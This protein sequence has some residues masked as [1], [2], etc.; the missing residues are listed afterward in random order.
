MEKYLSYFLPAKVPLKDLNS[1]FTKDFLHSAFSIIKKCEFMERHEV[2]ITN[3]FSPENFLEELIN[4][5]LNDGTL[6]YPIDANDILSNAVHELTALMQKETGYYQN[7]FNYIDKSFAPLIRISKPRSTDPPPAVENKEMPPE[8]T[9]CGIAFNSF[10]KSFSD[11]SIFPFEMIKAFISEINDNLAKIKSDELVGTES[12]IKSMELF[13]GNIL[14]VDE[15]ATSEIFSLLHPLIFNL[16]KSLNTVNFLLYFFK[17]VLKHGEKLKI[18][19]MNLTDYL[20]EIDES[21][22]FNKIFKFQEKIIKISFID[23][24]TIGVLTNQKNV[25]F[26]NLTTHSITKKI[27]FEDII[28]TNEIIN[29]DDY[30]ICI[31]SNNA[32]I[33]SNHLISCFSLIDGSRFGIVSSHAVVDKV[34]FI[35]FFNG[36][37]F[38]FGKKETKYIFFKMPN[39]PHSFEISLCT[40]VSID[41]DPI[42][43]IVNSNI[44]FILNFKNKLIDFIYN[45]DGSINR[46]YPS[47]TH[48]NKN[49]PSADFL[50]RIYAYAREIKEPQNET[51]TQ[52]EFSYEVAVIYT[53]LTLYKDYFLISWKKNDI[54]GEDSETEHKNKAYIEKMIIHLKLL[55]NQIF[56]KANFSRDNINSSFFTKS[57]SSTLLQLLELC[58]MAISNNYSHNFTIFCLFSL[59][60]NIHQG[61]KNLTID[62]I[63]KIIQFY[64]KM[65]HS[66][67]SIKYSY[68]QNYILLS[69]AI[70]HHTLYYDDLSKVKDDFQ[71]VFNDETRLQNLLNYDLIQYLSKSSAFVYIFNDDLIDIIIKH[72]PPIC[73]YHCLINSEKPY[74]K[75]ACYNPP[76]KILE[77]YMK[78][79]IKYI[80]A[81]IDDN[82]IPTNIY[83]D[84]LIHYANC[85][86]SMNNHIPFIFA[87]MVSKELSRIHHCLSKNESFAESDIKY[88]TDSFDHDYIEKERVAKFET[89]HGS[90]EIS[91][92]KAVYI[93]PGAA[94]IILEF[95]K[96]CQIPKK[97]EFTISYTEF[98]GKQ[99]CKKITKNNKDKIPSMTIKSDSV[100]L[101]FKVPHSYYIWR[102]L[103]NIKGTIKKDKFEFSPDISQFQFCYLVHLVGKCLN[104][105]INSIPITSREEEC[106]VL[107]SYNI[108]QHVKIE[109]Y[110]ELASKHPI[111]S[112][113]AKKDLY[114][115]KD[116]KMHITK[117]RRTISRGL[118]FNNTTHSSDML[119]S[120]LS[121]AS[122]QYPV[123]KGFAQVLFSNMYQKVP[124]KI[125]TREVPS[126]QYIEHLVASVMMK[127]LGIV[128]EALSYAMA[129]KNDQN[130]PVPPDLHKIWQSLYKIRLFLFNLNQK[131]TKKNDPEIF[132]TVIDE[133]KEKCLFLLNNEPILRVLIH[134]SES[135]NNKSSSTSSNNKESENTNYSNDF[136]GYDRKQTITVAI[137]EIS[138]FIMSKF[139]LKDIVELVDVRNKRFQI[140]M[141]A[142]KCLFSL[143]QSIDHHYVS[144]ILTPLLPSFKKILPV[145]ESNNNWIPM[146]MLCEFT[147]VISN[148][149]IYLTDRFCNV[150]TKLILRK[151]CADV[152]SLPFIQYLNEEQNQEIIKKLVT[153]YTNQEST[154]IDKGLSLI[155]I[156]KFIINSPNYNIVPIFKEL[157]NSNLDLIHQTKQQPNISKIQKK[158]SVDLLN[159]SILIVTFLIQSKKFSFDDLPLLLDSLSIL[160][161]NLIVSAFKLIGQQ[162]CVHGIP[163]NF[164][165]RGNKSFEDFILSILINIGKS[166]YH[167]KL[168]FLEKG[169]NENDSRLFIAEELIS[170]IRLQLLTF[171]S[172]RDQVIEIIHD[173]F[174]KYL[175]E[176]DVNYKHI[177][178]GLLSVLG[179]GVHSFNYTKSAI[180]TNLSN[181][182]CT[183]FGN[184]SIQKALVLDYNPIDNEFV[185]SRNGVYHILSDPKLNAVA[186]PRIGI[187]PNS[188]ILNEN[189]AKI[190]AEIFIK[191]CDQFDQIQSAFIASYLPI[192]FQNPNNQKLILEHIHLDKLISFSNDII[193]ANE[194]RPFEELASIISLPDM[195]H[196]KNDCLYNLTNGHKECQFAEGIGNFTIPIS[197]SNQNNSVFGYKVKI[198]S[199]T[200]NDQENNLAKSHF[201]FG[202]AS[203]NHIYSSNRNYYLVSPSKK[204]YTASQIFYYFPIILPKNEVEIDD[205]FICIVSSDFVYFSAV[206]NGRFYSIKRKDGQPL[207]PFIRTEN[208]KLSITIM[209]DVMIPEKTI[210]LLTAKVKIH[211]PKEKIEKYDTLVEDDFMSILFNEPTPSRKSKNGNETDTIKQAKKKV[212]NELN[213]KKDITSFKNSSKFCFFSTSEENVNLLDNENENEQVEKEEEEEEEYNITIENNEEDIENTPNVIENKEVEKLE[214]EEENEDESE[215]GEE[216]EHNEIDDAFFT[217]IYLQSLHELHHDYSSGN[218]YNI[219]EQSEQRN[220]RDNGG[221]SAFNRAGNDQERS[222]VSI[223]RRKAK[224]SLKKRMKRS[225]PGPFDFSLSQIYESGDIVKINK[226]VLINYIK[227]KKIEWNL[228]DDIYINFPARVIEVVQN[229]E[230]SEQNNDNNDVGYE[231]ISLRI[232][233]CESF[234]NLYKEF[235]LN[236]RLLN[237]INHFGKYSS[238]LTKDIYRRSYSIRMI[239]IATLLA[240]QTKCQLKSI[241]SQKNISKPVLSFL[242]KM[243]FEYIP[244]SASK[245]NTINECVNKNFIHP[246][247]TAQIGNKLKEFL[248]FLHY[249]TDLSIQVCDI[250]IDNWPSL[251]FED[252]KQFVPENYIFNIH[253]PTTK[254]KIDETIS[255]NAGFLLF[256]SPDSKLE[257]NVL[258]VTGEKLALK[259]DK[260][261]ENFH[262]DCLLLHEKKLHIL[263]NGINNRNDKMNL[264]VMPIDSKYSNKTIFSP[265]NILQLLFVFLKL[266][267]NSY[268]N[269]N[270]NNKKLLQQ[271][272]SEEMK[273]YLCGYASTKLIPLII[274]KMCQKDIFTLSI[275]YYVLYHLLLNLN[276]DGFPIPNKTIKQFDSFLN[277]FTIPKTCDSQIPVYIQQLVTIRVLLRKIMLSYL[278]EK[279]VA[280][281]IPINSLIITRTHLK[282]NV[283]KKRLAKMY[284]NLENSVLC[285]DENPTFRQLIHLVE[286]CFTLSCQKKFP[287]HMIVKEWTSNFTND[288]FYEGRDIFDITVFQPFWKEILISFV[289]GFGTISHTKMTIIDPNTHS[290][291]CTI[292]P[293]GQAIV[294]IQHFIIHCEAEAEFIKFFIHCNLLSGDGRRILFADKLKDFDNDIK[295]FENHWD[296]RFDECLMQLSPATE[297]VVNKF[298]DNY[299]SLYPLLKNVDKRLLIIRLEMIRKLNNEI[300]NLFDFTNLKNVNEPFT[301]YLMKAGASVGYSM[302]EVNIRKVVKSIALTHNTSNNKPE[303]VF[304]R[305]KAALYLNNPQ[306]DLGKSLLEQL[307][308]QL[309]YEDLINMCQQ[310]TPWT[311]ILEGEGAQDAGGPGRELFTQ[312]CMEIQDIRCNLFAVTP[313]RRRGNGPNQDLLIPNSSSHLHNS[314]EHRT[315][316]IFAGAIIACAY[317]SH[318]PQPFCFANLVWTSLIGKK[319]TI[320]QIYEIDEEFRASMESIKSCGPDV[321]FSLIYSLNFTIENSFGENVELIEGGTFINVDYERRLEYCQAAENFRLHEFDEYLNALSQGFKLFFG[322]SVMKLLSPWEARLLICGNIEIPI[323]ELKKNCKFIGDDKYH[324]MI[325]N[326]LEKFTPQE[327]MLFIKF[328]TGRMSLPPPGLEWQTPLKISFDDMGRNQDKML[329]TATTCSSKI[330]IPCYSSIEILETNLRIAITYASD[331]DQDNEPDMALN[332]DL[333]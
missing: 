166:F 50:N 31:G 333:A 125:K 111:N 48:S 219:S 81:Q 241:I 243:I 90:I 7:R 191:Y 298:P 267:Y 207:I 313:N 301:K 211:K 184:S 188:F 38:F 186:Q 269:N 67:I 317:T 283:E 73:V 95:D 75:E 256:M 114:N 108:L 226:T 292:P 149:F 44:T 109:S 79:A 326:V 65:L 208:T 315:K 26:I 262:H 251:S 17:A 185:I 223:N 28:S 203:E 183:I 278:N 176:S 173:I 127:H 62:I 59:L 297:S 88:T 120:F 139:N 5:Q 9:I 15:F 331:I 135:E 321:P 232:A 150:N 25:F 112:E 105:G 34:L 293:G 268:K 273:T 322:N 66:K 115:E 192:A 146:S 197:N 162:I 224:R 144:F 229:N 202:F 157:I 240:L 271:E 133:Y 131:A 16:T 61:D 246:S 216:E 238:P 198:I 288:I 123:Q 47:N 272:L 39:I 37:Y 312:I 155:L 318:L 174:V 154:E 116:G 137:N 276:F 228:Q 91:R 51:T 314:E 327:R 285:N 222:N 172:V 311:V 46:I 130:T 247:E 56:L 76:I 201:Y 42:G 200:S 158:I 60:I 300:A 153:L 119:K 126:I 230:D 167:E 221:E 237:R 70:N 49:I 260:Y 316:L 161:P 102:I 290:I 213:L 287:H 212:N 11:F 13:I 303:V 196:C 266:L 148:L 92:K 265:C 71:F 257:S 96:S 274:D 169:F 100:E 117:T 10:V 84:L 170:F 151:V 199:F 180:F 205:E 294:K 12:T 177:I 279:Q 259:L 36:D 163:D 68:I 178:I 306:S 86:Q 29:K 244:F 164:S 53:P 101:F 4:S 124:C 40:T 24:K 210:D 305:S 308:R 282:A 328:T 82:F 270:S 118:S 277:E 104:Y 218:D 319:I 204:Y 261:N 275:Y 55:L 281:N 325:F 284:N 58:E 98:D 295:F 33:S 160:R 64:H 233:F 74:F 302:K 3:R 32:I 106:K 138:S 175:D 18:S 129:L 113:N 57:P 329:P 307:I 181:I 255:S 1:D 22:Y 21:Q 263:M 140:R 89:E 236:S 296:R 19:E 107:L 254:M 264:I 195:P 214:E 52:N 63:Q 249:K 159:N 225:P 324:E 122:S 147:T 93:F 209:N 69:L 2:Q 77:T 289:D 323:E 54:T 103:C 309:K 245:H 121:D 189:D 156:I 168:D 217:Q 72:Y 23:E 14:A 193:D 235:T 239:R 227:N 231:D 253:K 35:S 132:K 97:A 248:S 8:K 299:S 194:L 99:I 320:D 41:E 87:K 165:Y 215:D 85:L 78:T 134:D 220:R 6:T 187:E 234:S 332:V 145:N 142:L 304:N 110:S 190:L 80:I 30:F 136:N 179:N 291:V 152:L 310:D 20:P 143:I 280:F 252:M 128:G 94:E 182:N 45:Y 83:Y 258:H 27:C 242:M 330:T 43:F 206:S 141:K 171:S 286:L 250:I